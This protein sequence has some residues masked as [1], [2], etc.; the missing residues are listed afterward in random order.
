MR[1]SRSPI[2]MHRQRKTHTIE[3]RTR[4]AQ[5]RSLN[6]RKTAVSLPK[7]PWVKEAKG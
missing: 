3:Q 7:A 4:E 2:W 1:T 5:A 6:R